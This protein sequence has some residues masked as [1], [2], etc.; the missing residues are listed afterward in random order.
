MTGELCPSC[1]EIRNMNTSTAT[2]TVIGEDG[3]KKKITT[4]SFHCE[5]CRQF[6][7]SEDHEEVIQE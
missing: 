5:H 6:V 4:R 2:R 3:K 7:R 1:K